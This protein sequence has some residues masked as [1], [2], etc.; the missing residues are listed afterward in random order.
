MINFI[1]TCL[2]WLLLSFA[3]LIF[4]KGIYHL[5]KN[6]AKNSIELELQ[7]QWEALNQK[8]V[9]LK[10]HQENTTQKIQQV[11]IDIKAAWEAIA[12][13]QN[14]VDIAEQKAA[15]K[16]VNAEKIREA[17]EL[18]LQQIQQVNE[19]LRRDLNAARQRAKRLVKQID[20]SA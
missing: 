3:V 18:K 6:T 16:L 4:I 17:V 12:K 2:F 11:N 8:S 15:E 13:E 9:A 5:L 14:E 1:E 20:T 19:K 7:Q 10:I